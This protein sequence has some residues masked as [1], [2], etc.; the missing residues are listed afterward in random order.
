MGGKFI[1]LG[2]LPYKDFFDHHLPFAW[3]LAAFILKFSFGSFILFRTWWAIFTFFIF[4][5]LGLH[6]K[7]TNK[8]LHKYYLF[9]FLLCPF[10]MVYFWLHLY[11][12]DGLAFIFFSIV[13]WLLTNESYK[14]KVDDRTIYYASFFNFLFI[15]SSLTF[16]YVALIF[17]LWMFYLLHKGKFG[18]PEYIKFIV[19]SAI[20]Y[21]SYFIYLLL[22]GSF[23]DFYFANIV[24]NTELYMSIPNYVRGPHFNPLK[25]MLTLIYNF[26]QNYLPL[27]IR[28]KDIDINFPI[29]LLVAWGSFLYLLILLIKD[30]ILFFFYF[31]ILSFSA[32]RSNPAKIGETDY[33][34][35]V[36]IALGLIAT[37]LVLWQYK[38]IKFEE[39]FLDYFRKVSVFILFLFLLFSSIFLMVNTYDKYYLRYTQKMP[40]IYD[41]SYTADFLNDIL[42][43][44]DYYWVGSYEPDEVFFVKKGRLPG[45]YISLMPQFR[46][47]KYLSQSFLSQFEKNTPILIIFKHKEGI[48]N[49]PADEFGK[50]FLDW[51]EEKYITLEG[52]KEYALIKSPS[53]FDIRSD[54]YLLNKKKDIL[55]NR[56]VNKGYLKRL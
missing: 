34:A 42:D 36:F 51:M 27:I 29:A 25:F 41:L 45:K 15:F 50:F 14:A 46:E 38:K 7:K 21:I 10:V 18:K 44:D 35:S 37:F 28:V 16:I 13:F 55:L 39:V 4:L 26:Y 53:S 22:T 43:T 19:I 40:G 8:E 11:I 23:N 49:T 2:K 6:L 32:P 33:Q 48:F 47:N 1:N 24:Y 9:F 54:F 3:Y 31:L 56:M 17:Y 20:P 30:R 5:I 12:A 52:I